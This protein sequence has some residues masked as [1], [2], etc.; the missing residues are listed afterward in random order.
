M[1]MQICCFAYQI[2]YL[3]VILIAETI[4]VSKHSSYVLFLTQRYDKQEKEKKTKPTIVQLYEVW[5]VIS[6][7]Q[8][9]YKH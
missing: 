6:Y 3:F 7:C 2:H 4:T 9:K 1:Y 8:L 5:N